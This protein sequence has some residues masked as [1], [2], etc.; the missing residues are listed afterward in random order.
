M[1]SESGASEERRWLVEPP[2][3]Q[4]IAFSITAGDQVDVTLEVRQ[5]FSDLLDAVAD[6]DVEG[7]MSDN[8]T[9]FVTGCQTNTYSCSPRRRCTTEA[10]AP[11]EMDYSCAI[12]PRLI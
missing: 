5:A 7:Y 3:A 8:C 12:A 1:T 6:A 2:G 9:G 10:Q 11:C 4:D